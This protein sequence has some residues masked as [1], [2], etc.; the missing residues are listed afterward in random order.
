MGK[1][2]AAVVAVAVAL[3]AT[4]AADAKRTTTYTLPGGDQTFPEGIG[5]DGRRH[6]YVSATG[7]G[8]IF[9]GQLNRRAAQVWLPGGAD[10]RTTAVGVNATRDR[11]YVA[12]GATGFVWVYDARSRRLLRRFE[13]GSGGFLNDIAVTGAGDAYVTDSF[14][15]V[16]WRVSDAAIDRGRG[17]SVAAERFIELG[18]EAGYGPGFNWNGI[19][20][21]SNRR[22][23]AVHSGAG[24]LFRI[25]TG[26]KGV[27]AIDSGTVDLTNGDGL[28]VRGRL[29]YVVRNQ[30][31]TIVRLR[32]SHSLSRATEFGAPITDAT[33]AYPT[34][35]AFAG[36]PLLVVNSQFDRRSAGLPGR[37]PFTVSSVPHP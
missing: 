21:S 17:D 35:A 26:T 29:L 22:L 5:F 8:T 28:A 11:V 16:L 25:D 33:F 12:G 36:G 13:T 6:F 27:A 20:A 31:A 7:D 9:R 15:P 32:L 23:V 1:R 34:T 24:R 18:P 3:V 19:E 4:P 10:G 14:R 37:L 30:Q 2:V